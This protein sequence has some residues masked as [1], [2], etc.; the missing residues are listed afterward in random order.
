MSNKNE[1]RDASQQRDSSVEEEEGH[2]PKG[3]G[4]MLV[5]I[6]A[7]AGGV[8]ALQKLFSHMPV[9]T[10]L[11][12][13]VLLHT[14]AEPDS[15]L[16][17]IIQ[18][19][20]SISVTAVRSS[21]KLRVN[22]IYCLPSD[23]E[24]ELLDGEVLVSDRTLS[25]ERRVPIDLFLRSVAGTYK[26]R[27][28]SIILSGTGSDG[29]LGTGRLRE[30][31]GVNIVQDPGQAEYAA[32]PRSAIEHGSVDFVLPLEQIPEKLVSLRR[33]AGRIQLPPAEGAAPTSENTLIEILGLLRARTRHDFISYKRSTVLRRIERRMQITECEDLPSY[34]THL[35]QHPEEVRGLLRDL[36]ISVTNF[37]RDPQSFQQLQSEILPRL[38]AEMKT[39][40]QL[41]VWVPGCATGEEAYSHAIIL[42]EFAELLSQPTS[43]QI[44]ATDIDE[45]ALAF[46]RNGLYPNSIAADVS[47]Q[48][49][50]RF[51]TNEGLF[52]R[53]KRE[54]RET[55][56]FAPQNLLRDPPFSKLNMISCR[57]LLIY[58]DRQ[59][60]E[61]L[62]ETFH[63]ALKPGGYLFLGSSE[64]A[65]G[66]SSGFSTV[67]K[68]SRIFQRD[69]TEAVA[70]VPPSAAPVGWAAV[71]LL[72]LTATTPA[73]ARGAVPSFAELHYRMLEAFGPPSVLI[74]AN[75]E[76]VHISEHAGRYLQMT[77]GEPSR[78]LLRAA[79][80]DVQLELRSLLIEASQVGQASRKISISIDG[81]ETLVEVSARSLAGTAALSG[82]SL[83][84]FEE[85]E[86]RTPASARK[87]AT[88]KDDTNAVLHNVEEQLRQTRDQLRATVEEYETSTEELKASNEEL[89]AMNEELRSASEELETGKEELQSLNEELST[90]N[91]ELKE[92]VEEVSRSNSDLQNLMASTRIATLFVDRAMC[93]KRYTPSL[94]Q[95]F[96]IIPTDV[97]RP[98]AH[99]THNLASN[100]LVADVERVLQD[101]QTVEREV[102]TKDGRWYI[103][104]LLPYRTMD[105]KITGVVITFTDIQERKNAEEALRSREER[106]RLLVESSLDYA[107]MTLDAQGNFDSWNPAAANI[108]GYSPTEIVG[109][110]FHTIFTAEDKATGQDRME[111]ATAEQKGKSVNE[112]WHVRKDGTRLYLSGVMVLINDKSGKGFAKIAR[113]L[114]KE[115]IAKIELAKSKEE[116]DI[117]VRERT[118]ELASANSQLRREISEHDRL[119]QQRVD[120][121]RRIVGTQEEERRRISR[122]LH[123]Q[124]GQLLTALRLR[125][126]SLKKQTDSDK[127]RQDVQELV[128][129]T[130]H[131]EAEIDFLAW[132]LRPT[133]L[134]D[135]GLEITLGNYVREWSE[136][137][138][139]PVTFH[140]QGL[141]N[142]R[143]T[144]LLETN[145]Y[146]IAQEGLNNIA[147]HSGATKAEILLE[148]RQ[149]DVVLILEDNGRGFAPEGNSKTGG[150]DLG[151]AGIRE[152]AQ[153][154]SGTIEIESAD[155]K[156]TTLFTR[157]PA[158]FATDDGN[159]NQ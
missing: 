5:A 66:L 61:R 100:N 118:E 117:R 64:S 6:G 158:Q 69:K 35:R 88:S 40:D 25:D 72:P 149:N 24:V 10:G 95:I 132:E 94:Q 15:H 59:A 128:E 29:S 133:M 16:A 3:G 103:L 105:D 62:L 77:G 81:K 36:L 89:Q 4:P 51:F 47:A 146:R 131:L 136:H 58:I 135:L 138:G 63:F 68:K 46:G 96:N 148:R 7:S 75:Y 39:G 150:R 121:V 114:T 143:L 27:A 102:S 21:A 65:D 124:L 18:R 144:W 13:V 87:T 155:G 56:L 142:H 76:I 116:L 86:Q 44:F 31:G 70:K 55:V 127:S 54:L 125:I 129:S 122:E 26:E 98:F 101:L 45:E 115:H 74:D 154:M 104:R 145:L 34:L 93:V 82:F 53:V 111:L 99:L 14:A 110:P 84:L 85:I 126:E 108:F 80:Q 9:T 1:A 71:P 83:V 28:I 109:Q 2:V 22:H 92:K 119:E 139:I 97:G 52:Y 151:L 120:L 107:I 134:D 43:L 123:D 157:L 50:R 73:A 112:R 78:N 19:K 42:T 159:A 140:A 60:Q 17:E 106:L 30:E 38:F 90:V 32:M 152:R 153:L 67:N 37:F 79:H 23:R 141:G 41:R 48:R 147:K 130:K 91:V 20:T 11:T 57:N 49:L 12:F 113:D 137:T 156:G 33:N 8:E